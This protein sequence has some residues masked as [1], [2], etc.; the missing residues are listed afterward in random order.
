MEEAAVPISVL[1]TRWAGSPHGK[2]KSTGFLGLKE[3]WVELPPLRF[4]DWTVDGEFLRDRV[5]TQDYESTEITWMLEGSTLKASELQRRVGA[6]LRAL[7]SERG[8]AIDR[9]V[10]FG[11][12]RVA[13]LFCRGGHAEF[14]C[15]DL[16][17]GA[18]SADISFTASAVEW[19]DVTYQDAIADELWTEMPR[20]N[21]RFERKAYE[22]TIEALLAEW[23]P[24]TRR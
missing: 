11:D 23:G 6:S 10:Q 14:V 15:G 16:A 13:V 1:G 17:C 8:S 21:F 9:E 24:A 3:E 2:T 5:A 22:A 18:V 7:L 12:G 4:L 19:R 20:R